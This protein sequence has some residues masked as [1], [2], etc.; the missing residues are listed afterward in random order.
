MNTKNDYRVCVYNDEEL[1]YTYHYE[2]LSKAVDA[3]E[4][5]IAQWVDAYLVLEQDVI[6]TT[7]LKDSRVTGELLDI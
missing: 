1:A 4:M 7:R 6:N 5:L 2:T 3:Y